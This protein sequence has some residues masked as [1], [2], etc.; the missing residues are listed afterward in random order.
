MV[1]VAPVWTGHADFC[2][3]F[4]FITFMRAVDGLEFDV[5]LE[6]KVKDLALIRLRPDLLRYAPD[7][8]ARFGLS[9]AEAAL[10]EQEEAALLETE[11]DGGA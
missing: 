7:V 6:A 8:A 4:E 9:T 3:P 1:N 10:L 2:H 11:P 5:M